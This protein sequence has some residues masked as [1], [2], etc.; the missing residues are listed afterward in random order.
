MNQHLNG[1]PITIFGDGSQKRAFSYIG[2]CVEPLWNAGNLPAVSGE[3]INLGGTKEISIDD[4][5]S[6][7]IK[8]IGGGSKVYKEA[9][10]EVKNA[11]S[12]WEKSVDLLAYNEKHTLEDGLRIMWQW[13]KNQP[14]RSQK[15]WE[16]YELNKGIY[17]YWK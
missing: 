9:R 10:H 7:L 6:L 12:T 1:E 15:I 8:V 14:K 17:S 11:W 5:A 3:I 13:V 2:D 4:A 16:A